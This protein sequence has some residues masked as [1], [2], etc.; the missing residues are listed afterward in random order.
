[1]ARRSSGLSKGGLSRLMSKCPLTPVGVI[2]PIACG[3]WLCTSFSS[4]TVRLYG[5]T[6]S[7]LPETNPSIAV[8]MFLMIGNSMLSRYGRPGFQ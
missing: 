6:M 5:Q 4:G 1:M 3:T 8:D 2:S 7:N